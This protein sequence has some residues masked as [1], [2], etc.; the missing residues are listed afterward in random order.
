[1]IK[2]EIRNKIKAIKWARLSPVERYLIPIFQS[3]TIHNEKDCIYYIYNGVSYFKYNTTNNFLT[4][5]FTDVYGHLK[6]EFGLDHIQQ[7]PIIHKLVKEYLKI[8]PSLV[9]GIHKTE[10]IIF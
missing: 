8:N 6:D 7:K 1:M 4:Y 5:S 2:E 9:A 3:L 10:N